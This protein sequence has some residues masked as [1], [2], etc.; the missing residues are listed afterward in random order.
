MNQ[1]YPILSKPSILSEQKVVEPGQYAQV[2]FE[3]I[4][5]S[6]VLGLTPSK[7]IP[8]LLPILALCWFIFRSYSGRVFQKSMLMITAFVLIL[9]FYFLLY[10]FQGVN[11]IVGSS[12]VSI[13]T[14]SSFWVLWLL[15][16]RSI[17]DSTSIRRYTSII[18]YLILLESV[19]GIL[20]Y[21]IV[22]VTRK[23]NI[24]AG[25]A[26]QGTVGLL[27]FWH[28]DAGFGNQIFIINMVFLL[29]FYVPHV[30]TT[31]RGI[32]VVVLG[33]ISIML[34]GVM[35]VFL[36]LMFAGFLAVVFYRPR[37][38]FSDLLKVAGAAILV[39]MLLIPF[40]FIFPGISKT[41]LLY[42]RLYEDE[43]SPKFDAINK[44]LYKLP[45]KYPT[46]YL[47][48][49]GPGQYSSRAGLISSGRYLS[50]KSG[51]LPN[52]VSEPF[53]EFFSRT[54][55]KYN[56]NPNR[57]GN[58]TMHRPFFSLLSVFAEFGMIG[59]VALVMGIFWVFLK[60]RKMAM[61]YKS[62]F[63]FEYYL[64]FGLG[65]IIAS[66]I[67]ISFFEN[68]LETTQAMFP[69]LLLFKLF[70]SYLYEKRKAIEAQEM[71]G[72]PA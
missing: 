24:L 40:E 64:S 67:F 41:A 33:L 38:L 13:I 15:P 19:I 37:F 70:Y 11:F 10:Y 42:V 44:T 8:L 39:L 31:R 18:K 55:H 4:I 60:M 54:W 29:M 45:E 50:V 57:Y 21:V 16:S 71:N 32:P 14:Y 6:L 1:T 61:W 49:L 5:L 23:F 72:L 47:V 35:H 28:E 56:S 9:G 65:I 58:S 46:V 12:I 63:K 68:Y 48:G 30:L 43:N 25:D 17:A 62:R 34:A 7:S 59:F 66:L 20:Q 26:V 3:I 52:T 69:G 53:K 22:V 2:Y 36:S 51:L 27:A